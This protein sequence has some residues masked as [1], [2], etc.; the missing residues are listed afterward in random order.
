MKTEEI[1]KKIRLNQI[2][3]KCDMFVSCIPKSKCKKCG[4]H[5]LEHSNKATNKGFKT[6]K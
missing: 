5:Y 2:K 3:A 4:K 1:I 6:Q